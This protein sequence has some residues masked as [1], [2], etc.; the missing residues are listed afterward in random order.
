MNRPD[1]LIKQC[2]EI[3]DYI[4]NLEKALDNACEELH[5]KDCL[6]SENCSESLKN[7]MVWSKESWKEWLLN[8]GIK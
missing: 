3:F 7:Y 8:D 6:I 2:H 5:R 1:G 4:D